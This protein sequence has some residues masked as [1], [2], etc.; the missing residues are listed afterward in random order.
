MVIFS[1][2]FFFLFFISWLHLIRLIAQVSFIFEELLGSGFNF[3]RIKKISAISTNEMKKENKTKNSNYVQSKRK[4]LH[5]YAFWSLFNVLFRWR[6]KYI[7]FVVSLLSKWILNI[8]LNIFFSLLIIYDM[9]F[10]KAFCYVRW[11]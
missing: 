5:V 10:E 3:L 6:M 8:P 4:M 2:F 7:A 9:H 1:L 11:V